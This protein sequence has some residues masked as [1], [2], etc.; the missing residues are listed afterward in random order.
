MLVG[1]HRRTK[2]ELAKILQQVIQTVKSIVTCQ[3]ASIALGK[4]F[5]RER[6]QPKQIVAAIDHHINCQVIAGEHLKFG[7]DIITQAYSF[8]LLQPV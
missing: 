6:R 8:P 7:S 1:R 3:P 2:H 5:R 4:Y